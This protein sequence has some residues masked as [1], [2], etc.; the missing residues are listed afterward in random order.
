MLTS[1]RAYLSRLAPAISTEAGLRANFSL[2][3]PHLPIAT[4][5]AKDEC[6]IPA[7]SA[8]GLSLHQCAWV[9]VTLGTVRALRAH[10][11]ASGRM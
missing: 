4:R 1:Y 3:A 5:G 11:Q 2:T 7:I 9:A 10:A 8:I 6:S